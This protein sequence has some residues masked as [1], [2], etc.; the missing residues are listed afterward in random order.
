MAQCA[1][2]DVIVLKL[3]TYIDDEKIKE[4]EKLQG[5]DINEAKIMLANFVTEMNHGKDELDK[6]QDCESL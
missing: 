5:S 4:M 1:C 6:V 2:Q 3:Y